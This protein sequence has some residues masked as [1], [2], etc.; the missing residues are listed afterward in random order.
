M[1]Q[2]PY[3]GDDLAMLVL[4]PRQ[5]DGLAALEQSLNAD[6]LDAWVKQLRETKVNV[7]FPKFKMTSEFRLDGSL[8]KMG[9][10]DAFIDGQADF[11]GLNGGEEDLHIQAV[12]HKAFV[13]V[14]EEGTEAAAATGVA[15]GTRSIEIL[16]DFVADHP[17]VFVIRSVKDGSVLFVGRVANPME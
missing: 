6:N 3:A 4:L 5:A 9:M 11:S 14:N 17:F 12:V 8:Q 1:L 16:P 13:E 2:M 10:V 15:V 7:A